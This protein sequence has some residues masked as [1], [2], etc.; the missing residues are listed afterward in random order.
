MARV[1]LKLRKREERPPLKLELGKAESL[2]K[3]V[4]ICKSDACKQACELHR[5]AVRT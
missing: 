5:D 3:E 2:D 4:D 1:Q